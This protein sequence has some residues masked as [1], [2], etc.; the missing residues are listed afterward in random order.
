VILRIKGMPLSEV[1]ATFGLGLAI[2]EL[3]RYFDFVGFRYTLP[4][5]FDGSFS[6]GDVYID[7]QRLIIGLIAVALT[8]GPLPL[9]QPHPHGAGFQGHCPG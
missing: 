5:F 8:I 6:I 7:Y 3:F 4:I 2:M 9:Y 1:M